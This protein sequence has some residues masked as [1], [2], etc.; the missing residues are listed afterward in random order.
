MV[1]K[2]CHE[3]NRELSIVCRKLVYHECN[4]F[5]VKHFIIL[6]KSWQQVRLLSNF[7]LMVKKIHIH[8]TQSDYKITDT[9]IVHYHNNN[10]N[11]EIYYINKISMYR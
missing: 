10:N 11:L 6:K 9:T 8:T 1:Y 7:L 5:K 3:Q 2:N 4:K